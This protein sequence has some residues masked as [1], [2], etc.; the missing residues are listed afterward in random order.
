LR[1]ELLNHKEEI[2]RRLNEAAGDEIVNEII[3]N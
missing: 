2:I 3:F 1:E